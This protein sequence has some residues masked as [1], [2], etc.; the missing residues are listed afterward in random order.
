MTYP[1]LTLVD[2]MPP[3]T[4]CPQTRTAFLVSSDDHGDPE[5]PQK[6]SHRCVYS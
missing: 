5:S 2:A 1:A 6:V 3:M 4:F